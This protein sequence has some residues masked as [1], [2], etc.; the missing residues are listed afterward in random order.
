MRHPLK[1]DSCDARN[2][3]TD[4]CKKIVKLYNNNRLYKEMSNNAKQH[5]KNFNNQYKKSQVTTTSGS[6]HK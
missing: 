2:F 4:F 5:K 6:I 1:T 3:V